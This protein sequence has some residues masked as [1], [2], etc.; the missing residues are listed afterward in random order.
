MVFIKS[1]SQQPSNLWSPTILI[2]DFPSIQGVGSL[3]G[4]T[5]QDSQI[6]SRIQ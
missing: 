1:A 4:G 3:Y 5:S 6:I 2:I